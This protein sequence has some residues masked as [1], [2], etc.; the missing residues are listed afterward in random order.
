M[1]INVK[2]D[3]N[4]APAGYRYV[5][6]IITKE[7][8]KD[9]ELDPKFVTY[10]RIGATLHLCYM[11][12]IEEEKYPSYM[13][14]L[15]AEDKRRE[16]ERRCLIESPKT[17]QLIMCP[18]SNRCYGCPNA[19][20]PDMPKCSAI[21][22]DTLYEKNEYELPDATGD[23]ENEVLAKMTAEDILNDL[24]SANTK[25]ARIFE[26]RLE[27]YEP[28]EISEILGI[29]RSTLYDD[30]KKIAKIAGKYINL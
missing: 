24:E 21:S 10:H 2:A 27:G 18:E 5:P 28:K 26:L 13:A 22:I 6:M 30:M 8:I 15:K 23:C 9:W 14:D 1:S 12:P 4:N 7:Q 29:K 16:R 17:G 3:F 11:V 25:L 19:G 20:N